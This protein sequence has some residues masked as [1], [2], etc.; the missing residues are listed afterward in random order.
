MT[1]RWTG[2]F[3]ALLS[4]L[5]LLSACTGQAGSFTPSA[6]NFSEAMVVSVSSDG[7][8]A[9]SS[10]RERE[11]VL[12]DIAERSHAVI[13]RNAN[14]YSAY[15]VPQRDAFLW[16]D[17]DD[18]VRVQT[19]EG[20]ELLRFRH[21]PTYGHV[22]GPDLET[23]LASDERWRLY[24]G[25]GDEQ[26]PIKQDGESPSFVGSGKLLN[27]ALSADAERV[28]S[29]GNSVIDVVPISEAPAIE[30][31]RIY[32]DYAGVVLWDLTT[33]EP[34]QKFSGNSAKTHAG[35]SPD[36]EYVVSVDENGKS[37]VWRS[38]SGAPAYR[39][40][41]LGSGIFVPSETGIGNYDKR[42][43]RLHYPTDF[44]EGFDGGPQLNVQFVGP[45]HYVVLHTYHPYAVLYELG[46]PFAHA[47]MDLGTDPFPATDSY[48]RNAAIDSA[49]EANILVTGQRSGGGINVYRF[50]PERQTL[51]RLWA[52]TP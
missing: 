29:S 32:S 27:L 18:L 40:S 44:P 30:A 11:L 7:R 31:D 39:P 43:L 23:Y 4:T 21:F 24:L 17:L 9:I 47:I 22:I 19:V 20:E 52:P 16:Q 37:F 33:G 49:P 51:E 14:I 42:N 48:A 28:V 6:T 13:S 3:A 2:L 36:G 50:D 34:L 35:L 46:D 38:A 15:F 12:W 8:Y 41:R 10:H 45:E 1:R 25:W 26:R 5:L